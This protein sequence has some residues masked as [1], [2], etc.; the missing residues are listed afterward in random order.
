MTS[1][2]PAPIVRRMAIGPA[3]RDRVRRSAKKYMSAHSAHAIRKPAAD[4]HL[5]ESDL[6]V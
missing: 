6:D 2:A 4:Y 5:S 3:K 1:N